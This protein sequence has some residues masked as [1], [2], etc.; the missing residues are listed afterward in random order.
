MSMLTTLAD[1]HPEELFHLDVGL[2]AEICIGHEMRGRCS[3]QWGGLWHCSRVL[4]VIAFVFVRNGTRSG[5]MLSCSGANSLPP[6]R[7]LFGS[8]F[9]NIV[10]RTGSNL[11]L[12][13]LLVPPLHRPPRPD[14]L[15]NV[16][17][18]PGTCRCF[19]DR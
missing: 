2:R 17:P 18:Q 6:L 4:G 3:G 15:P 5:R 13:R 7:W 19:C 11:G 9:I 14:I 16:L 8:Q 12:W 10:R 1:R